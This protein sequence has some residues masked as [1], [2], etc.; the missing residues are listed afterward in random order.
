MPEEGVEEFLDRTDANSVSPLVCYLLKNSEMWDLWPLKLRQGLE[1]ISE[2]YI[3]I[4][5]VRKME[6]ENILAVFSKENIENILLKGFPLSYLV[7]PSAYLRPSADIDFLIHERDNEKIERIVKNLGYTVPLQVPSHEWTAVK[8]DAHQIRHSLDFHWKI[9]NAYTFSQMLSFE[10]IQKKSVLLPSFPGSAKTLCL[11]QALF[12]AAIHRTGH[13]A[14]ESRLIWLYDIHLIFSRMQ[15][16]EIDSFLT[17]AKEKKAA[18][19]CLEALTLTKE[20]IGTAVS[21]E[22][23]GRLKRDKEEHE[24]PSASY[25]KRGNPRT[26]DLIHNVKALP[27]KERFSFLWRYAFPGSEYILKKYSCHNRLWVPVLYVR[28]GFEGLCKILK[29]T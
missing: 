5:L 6:I 17:L 14:N 8:K 16:E 27:P 15:K 21:E 24:E 23:L 29:R 19:I 11:E 18:A 26:R 4:Y 7:Y 22:V 25:L 2:K 1:A 3:A 12:L 28:R 9:S 10:E 13:H 20:W